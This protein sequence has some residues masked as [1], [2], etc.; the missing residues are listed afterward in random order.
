MIDTYIEE[1]INARVNVIIFT[2]N[3]F[4]FRGVIV[5]DFCDHIIVKSDNKKSMIYKHAISTIQPQ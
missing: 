4:Q 2:T 3:G 1:C 5:N